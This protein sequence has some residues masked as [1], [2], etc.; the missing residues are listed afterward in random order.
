MCRRRHMRTLL[1]SGLIAVATCLLTGALPAAAATAITSST[2]AGYAAHSTT[3]TSVTASWVQPTMSCGGSSSYAAFWVGLD[4]YSSAS[5][6]QAGTEADCS[7]GTP[8]YYA[9]YELYPAAPVNLSQSV[10]PGDSMTVTV[11]ATT[12]DV[13][14]I[15]VH[16]AT[17]GWNFT[18]HQTDTAAERS[19]A[20]VIVEV[21][22]PPPL[23]KHSV[24]FTGAGVNGGT[25]GASDPTLITSP[26]VTCG[27]ITNGGTQFSCSW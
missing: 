17:E 21:P 8:V 20:E 5:T 25:L 14:T 11:S 15:T 6:E 16:N 18:T 27:S 23:G 4:G 19:S 1:C 13:F 10:K 7:G 24:T 12:K 3:Y 9:W 26:A 22:S 2:W